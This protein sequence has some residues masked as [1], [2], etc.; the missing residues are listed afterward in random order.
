MAF[1][2][3]NG[4]GSREEKLSRLNRAAYRLPVY[5]SQRG[6]PA[7]CAT[8]GSGRRHAYRTGLDTRWVPTKGFRVHLILLFQ[9]CPGALSNDFHKSVPTLTEGLRGHQDFTSFL[10]A[11]LDG[12]VEVV[13]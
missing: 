13:T 5:A 3:L 11:G 8:L 7:R 9:A 1:R 4:V 12:F 6:L 2:L 10:R